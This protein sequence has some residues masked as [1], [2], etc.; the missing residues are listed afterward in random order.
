[1][2][3]STMLTYKSW[4]NQGL[5]KSGFSMV[6]GKHSMKMERLKKRLAMTKIKK[7]KSG[8]HTTMMVDV[9]IILTIL[10]IR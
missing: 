9:K 1:M 5:I 10:K 7:I 4:K 8:S 6:S 3:L 2:T